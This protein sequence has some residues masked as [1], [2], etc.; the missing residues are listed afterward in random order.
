MI[1]F[2]DDN[3]KGKLVFHFI[4]YNNLH[5][6]CIAMAYPFLVSNSVLYRDVGMCVYCM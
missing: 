4:M 6:L 2:T 3:V 5:T 1:L